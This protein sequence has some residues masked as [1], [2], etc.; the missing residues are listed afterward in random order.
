M[1]LR[2]S[3]PLLL[4]LWLAAPSAPAEEPATQSHGSVSNEASFSRSDTTAGNPRAGTWTDR[5]AAS[6]QFGKAWS[7]D[8]GLAISSIEGK[9]PAA[10]SS[11]ETGGQALDLSGGVGWQAS[12][13]LALGLSFAL[14]PR[15]T[16]QSTTSLDFEIPG[17][18]NTVTTVATDA[19]LRSQSGGGELGL[20][21]T[22][23]TEG[24]GDL[25]WNF[26]VEV[27]G[28]RVTSEQ[29][30]LEI[31]RRDTGA[32]VTDADLKSFCSGKGSRS[33]CSAALQ[34]A[35]GGQS[36]SL[37]AGKLSLTAGATLFGDT[38]LALTLDGWAYAQDPSQ[39]GYFSLTSGA[40]GVSGGGGVPIAPMRS[41]MGAELTHRFG[42][43][44]VRLQGSAGRYVEQTGGATFSGGAKVQYRFTKWLRAWV[45]LSARHDVDAG[46]EGTLSRSG[47]GGLAVRF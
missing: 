45:T 32:L 47:A 13:Q 27:T 12:T 46:G 29:Q 31:H 5:L 26:G 19:E 11:F 2:S 7:L 24:E 18:S 36:Y 40:H 4:V 15:R 35:L 16:T 10:G 20:S 25:E 39:V 38:D 34:T 9:A 22:W 30:V 8:L 28:Q 33:R 44:S 43:L 3:A 37:D 42:D 6:F 14:S 1:S 17:S 41:A 21:A 23:E